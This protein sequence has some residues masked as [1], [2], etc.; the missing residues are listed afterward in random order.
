MANGQ[1]FEEKFAHMAEIRVKERVPS[2]MD[3]NYWVGFQLVHKSEDEKNA[4]G[5]MAFIVNKLWV[6][7]PVI[8][9]KGDLKGDE[10]LYIQNVDLRI[11][12]QDSWISTL[13]EKGM[14]F[15]GSVAK[16]REETDVDESGDI[17]I[18]V[19]EFSVKEA[20]ENQIISPEEAKRIF[21]HIHR[22]QKSFTE[23]LAS[24]GDD[25]VL[26]FSKTFMNNP[27]LT[28]SIFMYHTPGEMEKLS[29]L[30]SDIAERNTPEPESNKL[31][32]ITS[33][34]DK[35][36]REL[37]D[38]EKKQL[39]KNGYFI[40]DAREDVSKVF[41]PGSIE[42]NFS[43]PSTCGVH[44]ILMKDGS[45]RD[46]YILPAIKN[47]KEV[48]AVDAE[49]NKASV[50]SR[51]I[52]AR[53]R[54]EDS[55]PEFR[56]ATRKNLIDILSSGGNA[57]LKFRGRGYILEKCPAADSDES[58]PMKVIVN[59]SSW[60]SPKVPVFTGARGNV[61]IY[62]ENLLIPK[63]AKLMSVNSFDI[64]ERP[65]FGDLTTVESVI[66]YDSGLKAVEISDRPE[67]NII[68]KTAEDKRNFVDDFSAVKNLV[69]DYG[70]YAGQAQS[71]VKEASRNGKA[72]YLI[73]TAADDDH[74]GV[75]NPL[76]AN[77]REA[78]TTT[79]Y[80]PSIEPLAPGVVKEL[81]QVAEQ[82]ISEV[83]DVSLFQSLLQSAGV[84]D[85]KQEFLADM[86]KGMDSSAGMLLLIYWN[87]D[88]FK[89]RYGD[90][91]QEMEDKLKQIFENIGDVV[92]FIKEKT[93]ALPEGGESVWGLM[94]EDMF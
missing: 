67:T 31:E 48:V 70:I 44:K 83:F 94:S 37:S 78:E 13:K 18:P 2:L 93:E 36:A 74:G 25:A 46:F 28:N 40:K 33:M 84:S 30:V 34:E 20:S 86:V 17:T 65:E 38:A 60:V 5:I 76:T 8:F 19:E 4:T 77:K 14:S 91:L 68:I 50:C 62:G 26:K 82:G 15:I 80:N 69:E 53:F 11:P 12:A 79:T 66:R 63:D 23:K 32:Y 3:S 58:D 49:N 7:I 35:N 43:N 42:G 52:F 9:I 10:I 16:A 85:F 90:D 39:H 41:K 88:M 54:K 51:D 27:E 87:Y 6:Y 64:N 71:M 45:Y 92:L 72:E 75:V 22:P 89:E 57:V 59:G 21:K 29:E 56:E 24:L 47:G 1:T 73:K 61:V 81:S 55:G